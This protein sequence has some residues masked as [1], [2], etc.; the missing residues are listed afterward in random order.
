M[1]GCATEAATGEFVGSDDVYDM[2]NA[3]IGELI[4]GFADRQW[5]Y[6]GSHVCGKYVCW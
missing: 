1:Y 5:T 6:G 4:S 2:N 3:E